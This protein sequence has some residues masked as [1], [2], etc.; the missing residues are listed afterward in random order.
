MTTN[1]K[2]PF[3]I[4]VLLMALSGCTDDKFEI[5]LNL[6]NYGGRM[7]AVYIDDKGSLA[8]S[9]SK[10]GDNGR[11]N[12]TGHSTEP[13]LVSIIGSEDQLLGQ[14]IAVNGNHITIDGDA[15]APMRHRIGGNSEL[16]SAWADWRRDH[17]DL[18]NAENSDKLNQAITDFISKQPDNPLATI[19]LVADY[20]RLSDFETTRR[21]LASISPKARLPRLTATLDHLSLQSDNPP[22]N[23]RGMLLMRLN[24]DFETFVPQHDRRNW[25]IVLWDKDLRDRKTLFSRARQFLADNPRRVAGADILA[26]PDTITWHRLVTNDSTTTWQHFWAPAGLSDQAIE[27]LQFSRLPA[28]VAT[29]SLGNI[30]YRGNQLQP[31]LN[32][33]RQHLS[34]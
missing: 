6:E 10:T 7:R 13:T 23:T 27:Y 18:Y 22:R 34:K 11:W 12:I 3:L 14:V 30:L 20:T 29:D 26:S 28:F 19:L 4:A 33:L 24:G 31:A 17:A 9:T 21:L 5:D 1:T 8:T 16:T 2:I 25:L 32:A 15:T